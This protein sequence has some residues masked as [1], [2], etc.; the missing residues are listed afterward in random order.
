MSIK[1]SIGEYE[2]AYQKGRF[3]GTGS[4]KSQDAYYVGQFSNG[5]YHGEGTLYVKGGQF[6][7]NWERGKLASGRFVFAD[8]LKF[9]AMN[10]ST[11]SYCSKTDPRFHREIEEGVIFGT[12]L[13]HVTADP[14]CPKLHDGCY[15]TIDGY[16]D[17]GKQAIL[18][19]S[20]NIV[21]RMPDKA[22]REWILKNCRHGT[23]LQK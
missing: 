17:P 16:Y 21:I 18:S 14:D 3:E 22:E 6:E 2:G 5:V 4:Y 10:E 12:P 7:G 9:K 19:Y 8:G 11:W 20:E 23:L 13:K 15:D 1:E